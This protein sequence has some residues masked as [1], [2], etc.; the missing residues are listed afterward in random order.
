MAQSVGT[1]ASYIFE[2]AG[3]MRDQLE[4]AVLNELQ[5]KGYPLQATVK[6]VKS[7]K[8]LMG[9]IAGTKEQCVVIDAA[10]GY[11]I[12]IANTT[13]GTYLYVGIYLMTPAIS[14]GAGAGANWAASVGDVFKLQK[15]NAYYA[16][17][18]AA[19]ESAFDALGLKQA[20]RGYKREAV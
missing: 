6:G 13:V 1:Q 18:I 19:T 2:G 4:Q 7:G 10:D 11:T 3:G 9:A 15:L 5:K 17:A 14:L 12:N 20:N 8:G 16:A